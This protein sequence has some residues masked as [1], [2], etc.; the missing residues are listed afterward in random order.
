MSLLQ[1]TLTAICL[2]ALGLATLTATAG[3]AIAD[4]CDDYSREIDAH[5]ATLRSIEKRTTVVLSS[6]QAVQVINLYV[7]E[8]I[9]WRRQMAPLDRAVASGLAPADELL[10]KWRGEWSRSFAP[11]FRDYAY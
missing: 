9:R 11:L 10:A 3:T 7:D 1:T 8:M 2:R 6:E 5:I 4:I